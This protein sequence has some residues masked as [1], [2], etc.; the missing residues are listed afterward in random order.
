VPEKQT[1]ILCGKSLLIDGLALKLKNNNEFE[2]LMAV[3][4]AEAGQRI[5]SVKPAAIIVDSSKGENYFETLVHR[6]PS[7]NIIAVNPENS[8]ALVYSRSK[9]DCFDD[10]KKMFKDHA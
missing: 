3:D 6:Y 2:V 8:D 5:E 9:L 7:E 10:L 4:V 1:V